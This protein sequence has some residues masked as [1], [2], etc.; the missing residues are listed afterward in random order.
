MGDRFLESSD[1]ECEIRADVLQIKQ[2]ILNTLKLSLNAK[3]TVPTRVV[4]NGRL[5]GRFDL[6][7]V[8]DLSL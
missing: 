3:Y 4:V 5:V 2:T 6:N 1:S 7:T 8:H